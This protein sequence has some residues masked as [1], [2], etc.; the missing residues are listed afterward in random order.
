MFSASDGITMASQ[1]IQKKGEPLMSSSLQPRAQVG[2]LSPQIKARMAGVLYLIIIFGGAFAQ[3]GVRDQLVV[4][5]DAAATARN[6]ITNQLLYRVGF[7]VE[8]FYVLW[9]IPLNIL[10]YDLFKIVDKKLALV[11]VF[12][13]T[14]G[15]AVQATSLLA[16][17]A[18]LVFLG[19]ASYLGAFTT[20]QLQAA[21]F[22]SLRLF[23]YG[24]M[25]A[26]S[27]FGMFCITLGY[28]ILRS[29]FLPRFLAALLAIEGVLYLTNSF[30]HFLA[31]AIGN[32]VFPFLL[33][34]GIAEVSFCLWLVVVGV[35]ARRWQEQA[36]PLA[37]SSR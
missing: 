6:I 1:P 28:L 15:A 18:P 24:Y 26:L 4:G 20:A 21:A 3:L 34:S 2:N 23:D 13:S 36:A 29:T 25:I 37:A 10:L 30:A 19:K 22:I 5:G 12:F 11:M 14:V 16:H 7:A 32:R 8:V 33:V 9:C 31:P 27:F 17:Y 35:N